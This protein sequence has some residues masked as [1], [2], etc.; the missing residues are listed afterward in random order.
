MDIW[1]CKLQRKSFIHRMWWLRHCTLLVQDGA[2]WYEYNEMVRWSWFPFRFKVSVEYHVINSPHKWSL[3][4]RVGGYSTVSSPEAAYIIGGFTT[5]NL[6]A[7][8]RND[9][10]AQLNDLNKGRSFHGSITVGARTMIVG[11]FGKWVM[12]W[13]YYFGYEDSDFFLSFETEVWE[14][15]SGDNKVISPTLTNYYDGIG[16]YAVNFNFCTWSF[17]I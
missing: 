2:F 14:L 8:F 12:I 17:L 6:V 11:G 7:E 13:P 5:K 10:W 16:L 9:Q 15:E 1:P 4:S 3:F